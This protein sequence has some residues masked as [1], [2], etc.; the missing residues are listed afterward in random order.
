M[1]P[2]AGCSGRSE[3]RP[4]T[5][6]EPAGGTFAAAESQ[7]THA[8]RLVVEPGVYHV[9]LDGSLP[10]TL[11]IPELDW[12]QNTSIDW[13]EPGVGWHRMLSIDLNL[14]SECRLEVACPPG[15]EMT[16]SLIVTPS[17][18]LGADQDEPNDTRE[19]AATQGW[20]A[21]GVVTGHDQDWFS[22]SVTTAGVHSVR[23][24][25]ESRAYF[26]LYSG[27][28]P[29]P[30]D[31]LPTPLPDPDL[32]W[33]VGPMMLRPTS[34]WDDEP[35][36]KLEAL[37]VAETTYRYYLLPRGT[38]YLRVWPRDGSGVVVAGCRYK[39]GWA[40]ESVPAWLR[41]HGAV[42]DLGTL[43]HTVP[44]PVDLTA[45]GALITAFSF[46]TLAAQDVCVEYLPF[47]LAA[48]SPA[49]GPSYPIRLSVLAADG[50]ILPPGGSGSTYLVDP[51]IYYVVLE[52]PID[53]AVS[54]PGF[55]EAARG[56]VV[57]SPGATA[58][59]LTGGRLRLVPERPLAGLVLNLELIGG[60]NWTARAYAWTLR[61]PAAGASLRGYGPRA[62]AVLP[63][64][65]H[66][67]IVTDPVTGVSLEHL[68]QV[69]EPDPESLRTPWAE[70]GFD[71]A[72]EVALG[73]FQGPDPELKF[74]ATSLAELE[75]ALRLAY[76]IPKPTPWADDEPRGRF[77]YGPTA[78]VSVDSGL[79]AAQLPHGGATE[80]Y[81][82]AG[83]PLGIMCRQRAREVAA[84]GG[85]EIEWE[86]Q[87]YVLDPEGGLFQD[88]PDS[89]MEPLGELGGYPA[90]RRGDGAAAIYLDTGRILLR[91][92]PSTGG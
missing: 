44:E 91:Y 57:V 38:Y 40:A 58:G 20:F 17:D 71:Q 42:A 50:T 77:I 78:T 6:G 21:A 76:H 34:E 19:Q 81:V 25:G 24:T 13:L 30:L 83:E 90:Y 62:L 64:G 11:S 75:A 5:L 88:G 1:A 82:I 18:L 26:E 56:Y 59:D 87:T 45:P 15:R 43:P 27:E 3:Q 51:G 54:E 86:G 80:W 65:T 48:D 41:A 39:V 4:L 47:G 73:T 84:A 32:V 92:V 2:L 72:G 29:V 22:F 85:G 12:S 31:P 53:A 70:F 69:V 23:L 79:L 67:V 36:S 7:T 68:I 33:E 52:T 9:E 28:D 89:A 16:Y 49:D 8:Y 60:P 63:A 55:P 74:D 37:A 61:E 46:T 10:C 14:P 35:G 66:Y